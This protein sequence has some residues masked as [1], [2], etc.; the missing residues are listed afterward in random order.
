MH[1]TNCTGTL[2]T[3]STDCPVA[4]GQVPPKSG[5]VAEMLA[6]APSR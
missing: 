3:P 5:T 4:N 1:T 2:I 6:Q